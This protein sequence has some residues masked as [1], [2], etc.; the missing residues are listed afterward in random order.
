MVRIIGEAEKLATGG[1]YSIQFCRRD[2]ERWTDTNIQVVANPPIT[3][4]H[5]VKRARGLRASWIAGNYRIGRIL[6]HVSRRVKEA[7]RVAGSHQV[8]T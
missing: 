2:G 3:S 6:L 7:A 1:F 8:T 4:L 5:V